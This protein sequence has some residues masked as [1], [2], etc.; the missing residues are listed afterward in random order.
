MSSKNGTARRPPYRIHEMLT[1]RRFASIVGSNPRRFGDHRYAL[2]IRVVNRLIASSRMNKISNWVDREFVLNVKEGWI[3]LYDSELEHQ[4]AMARKR[5][6][7]RKT[8]AAARENTEQRW[9]FRLHWEQRE[10]YLL[11]DQLDVQIVAAFAP[12]W[13]GPPFNKSRYGSLEAERQRLVHEKLT[14]IENCKLRLIELDAEADYSR[15]HARLE[16]FFSSLRSGGTS[17]QGEPAG[18]ELDAA[19]ALDTDYSNPRARL[20]AFFSLLPSEKT[21]L[22]GGPAGGGM[23]VVARAR[24]G[25][26]IRCKI[27]LGVVLH[28]I[29]RWAE[30]QRTAREQLKN[31]QAA[32]TLGYQRL[33]M[34]HPITQEHIKKHILPSN[35][36]IAARLD[37]L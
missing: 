8:A 35:T 31:L 22:K 33:W 11:M 27:A 10:C 21:T 6:S 9:M 14:K 24:Y 2:R 25:G 7:R 29:Q 34:S 17:L 13:P 28:R 5:L 20:Q 19:F 30:L 32:A 36:D 23:D 16:A 37:E 4:L 18:G 1:P 12:S 26:S 15:T 3:K